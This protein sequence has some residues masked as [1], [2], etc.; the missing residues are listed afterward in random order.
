MEDSTVPYDNNTPCRDQ[1]NLSKTLVRLPQLPPLR[2]A[3]NPSG[4]FIRTSRICLDQ[5]MTN[6]YPSRQY[7]RRTLAPVPET[8]P[9]QTMRSL[10]PHFLP[11][12]LS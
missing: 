5:S 12:S 6:I 2:K 1:V 3:S 4:E 7:Q 8:D 10:N 9:R 11:R